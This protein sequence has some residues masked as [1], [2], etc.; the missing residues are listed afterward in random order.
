MADAYLALDQGTTST[1]A[2]VYDGAGRVLAQAQQELE[3]H[4]PEPGQVEHDAEE[5]ATAA[6]AVLREA[7]QRA[8]RPGVRA[9]GITN[10]RETVVVFERATGKPIWR[11]IVW[12]DRRTAGQLAGMRA[13]ADAVRRSTGLPL[14]PY[15]SA[16]KIAWILDRVPGARVRAEHG[17]LCAATIDTWLVHRLTGGARFVTE[18]SNA[19]R[20]SLFDLRT[21]A[22][23]DEL[24]ALFRVPRAMLAEVLPSA[25]DFGACDPALCGA[26][27]PIRGVLGDQQ[28]ALFGHGGVQPGDTK[29]TYGTGAFVV[30]NAGT[31]VPEAREGLLA[32]VAWRI[33]GA[34]TYALE[35][36]VLVAGAAV[37]WLRDGLGIIAR[38]ADVE[39]LAR[40]V[41]DSG[42]VVFVPAFAGLGTPDWD[43]TARGM[44]IGLVRGTTRGHI[45][46]ATLEAIAL[47]V[48]E[49]QLALERATGRRLSALRVD[50][51][52]CG[53]DLLLELQAALSG[54][55]VLRPDDLET[56]ARG[57]LRIAM[58]GD[59]GGDP[60]AL[61]AATRVA[62]RFAPDPALAGEATW[63]RWRR[64]VERCR[65]WEQGT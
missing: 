51:G 21:G 25:G 10:Q 40:S 18:P 49:V 45:A 47:Q 52:A 6:T 41:A 29:C 38:S 33:G 65:G 26:A 1:R 43:P 36:S 63:Q 62:R 59:R 28:A 54:V 3:Q 13:H 42:G 44:L 35:G 22:W 12:Q 48:R 58:L 4:Y 32:T 11:A 30:C 9:L 55:E 20:T 34:T 39:A 37:Q 46:R 31:D 14:D 2:V 56:T 19:S 23:S 15:F 5:I 27:F 8:G 16:A 60:A 50:G 64:A 57:A 7:W 24:C 53:N 17:E 61:G